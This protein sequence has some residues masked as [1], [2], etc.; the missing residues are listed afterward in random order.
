MIEILGHYSIGSR[1]GILV[2]PEDIILSREIIRTSARNMIKAEIANII[3]HRGDGAVDV[4]LKAD[5]FHILSRITEQARADLELQ[6]HDS[7]FAIFKASSPQIIRE[8]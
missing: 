3:N 7:I 1:V 4:L 6:K 2:K 8:E 5:R